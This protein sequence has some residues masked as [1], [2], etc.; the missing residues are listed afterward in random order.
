MFY[1]SDS[2]QISAANRNEHAQM[3]IHHEN[4]ILTTA[5]IQKWL[6]V[7]QVIMVMYKVQYICDICL[8][9]QFWMYYI[10]PPTNILQK[11]IA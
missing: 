5:K 2:H 6:R 7:A 8:P 3:C 4:V 11:M 9:L 10:N 1:F